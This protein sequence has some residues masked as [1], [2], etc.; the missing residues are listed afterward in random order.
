M[1]TR[2]VDYNAR[3]YKRTLRDFLKEDMKLPLVAQGADSDVE[4]FAALLGLHRCSNPLHPQ[5]KAKS[6]L[7]VVCPLTLRFPTT[8]TG[9]LDHYEDI[10]VCVRDIIDYGGPVMDVHKMWRLVLWIWLGN[11]G[12][13]HR[14]WRFLKTLPVGQKYREGDER[15]PLEILNWTI[16]A[17]CQTGGLM[18]VIGSDGLDKKSRLAGNRI[19]YLCDWHKAVPDLVSSFHAGPEAFTTQVRSIPGLKGDLSAK[20]ITIM[21]MASCHDSIRKVAYPLP[22]GQGAK[23]GAYAF[24]NIKQMSGKDA[25]RRYCEQLEK[26]IPV[27]EKHIARLYPSLKGSLRRVSIGDI[28]P[29]LCGAFV[30]TGLIKKFRK[31]LPPALSRFS[32][33]RESSWAA[34]I[35]L[36]TPAGFIPHDL[37]GKRDSGSRLAKLPK[38]PYENFKLTSVPPRRSLTRTELFQKWG[39]AAGKAFLAKQV[40]A[41]KKRRRK[42]VYVVVQLS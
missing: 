30:Y 18:Q 17:V 42:K 31:S 19:L 3:L 9:K 6:Q 16:K 13:Q 39:G 8:L 36:G 41:M 15:Q 32:W 1:V 10:E 4:T 12:Q 33:N 21:L 24:L 20:E 29:C 23:N 27:M 11:G 40:K 25:D 38:I 14:P 22:F 7:A 28:E 2:L 35:Q 26:K 34:V 37:E 5:K